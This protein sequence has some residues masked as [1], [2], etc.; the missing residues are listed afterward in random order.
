MIVS[1]SRSSRSSRLL[2]GAKVGVGG[3]AGEERG[4]QARGSCEGARGGAAVK[5]WARRGGRRTACCWRAGAG[6]RASP[7]LATARSEIAPRG[8]A[9][10]RAD[11][12]IV[13]DVPAT[14]AAVDVT[15][16]PTAGCSPPSG[17]GDR[18]VELRLPVSVRF[19]AVSERDLVVC[20]FEATCL[21]GAAT[22]IDYNPKTTVE[23]RFEGD[24]EISRGQEQ[25]AAL[26]VSASPMSDML[27]TSASGN[28]GTKE[29]ASVRYKLTPPVD[30]VSAAGTIHRATGVYF[31]LRPSPRRSLE[32]GQELVLWLRVRANWRSDL[33]LVRC[34]AVGVT[35]DDLLTG[36]ETGV[37]GRADFQ[38][39]V[40][41]A[42]DASGRDVADR[43]V[44]AEETFRRDAGRAAP[45][46]RGPSPASLLRQ[47][48]SAFD[49][50]S[51][52]LPPNWATVLVFAPGEASTARFSRSLPEGVLTSARRLAAARSEL[53]TGSTSA[54]GVATTGGR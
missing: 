20:Q 26:S 31:K 42:G 9:A 49:G 47:V 10:A 18:I 43:Y 35:G 25:S 54:A 37:L 51:A 50:G 53:L 46:S 2:R 40:Y 34:H 1:S 45:P 28:I 15:A 27:K 16:S 39:P 8:A 29:S 11:G 6:R 30:Q 36:R 41:E 3:R 23:P 38:V 32:G 13:F 17:D 48:G 7:L 19:D 44:R 5:A 22:V 33:L 52:G 14:L 24:V 4:A 21:S 12:P